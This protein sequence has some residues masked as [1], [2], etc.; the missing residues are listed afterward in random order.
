MTFI[1]EYGV[2][3]I[4]KRAQCVGCLHHIEIGEPALR[5]VGHVDGD[6]NAVA[7]HPEC[8]DAE[9]RLNHLHCTRFGDDWNDLSEI[10]L[11]D[12][13]WLLAEFPNVA[14]RFGITAKTIAEHLEERRRRMFAFAK[15]QP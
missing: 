4:R 3:A 1:R 7:Y 14:A 9:I 15:V 6:F 13:E 10:E 5:W 8:R 11:D 2:K 12:H